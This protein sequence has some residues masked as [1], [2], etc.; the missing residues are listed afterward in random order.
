MIFALWTKRHETPPHI[1]EQGRDYFSCH[2]GIKKHQ[3]YSKQRKSARPAL[4]CQR[5]FCKSCVAIFKTLL[6]AWR[7]GA[8]HMIRQ[9]MTN[10]YEW[11]T[12]VSL[13][14]TH[15]TLMMLL[16]LWH[17]GPSGMHTQAFVWCLH[18]VGG[19]QFSDTDITLAES[20]PRERHYMH[21]WLLLLRCIR[22]GAD[23]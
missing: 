15:V 5:P 4:R 21:V 3:L 6:K 2:Q 23:D 10:V 17:W 18:S 12:S 19:L 20:W 7:R 16:S 11:K 13:F 9:C 14:Q 8:F 22:G 1:T